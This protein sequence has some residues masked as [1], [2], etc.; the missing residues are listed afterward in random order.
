MTVSALRVRCLA[1]IFPGP[2]DNIKGLNFGAGSIFD[3]AQ[4]GHEL[5]EVGWRGEFDQFLKGGGEMLFDAVGREVLGGI[6]FVVGKEIESAAVD[7]KIKAQSIFFVE[8]PAILGRFFEVA[9]VRHTPLEHAVCKVGT[10]DFCFAV[11]R[12]L[13]SSGSFGLFAVVA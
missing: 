5:E 10:F 1:L 11:H 7:G 4:G 13:S 8:W 6:E 9:I 12:F 2:R 3:A